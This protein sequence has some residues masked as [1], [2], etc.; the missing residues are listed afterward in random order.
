MPTTR[1]IGSVL[2]EAR[3]LLQDKDNTNPAYRYSDAELMEAFN[4]A[5]AEVKLK[6][7]DLFLGLFD[8]RATLP[9]YLTTDMAL[10]FPLPEIYY[11][12]VIYYVVGRS[13]LRDD[14]Y[15]DDSRA[16]TMMNKFTSQLLVMSS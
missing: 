14:T 15:A 10:V 1:S 5:M 13:S 2:T 11:N 6:R 4:G 12:A 3:T 9:L 7:P 8:L 16:V